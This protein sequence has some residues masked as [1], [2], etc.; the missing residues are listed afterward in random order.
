M[1]RAQ[2]KIVTIEED[3]HLGFKFG[4]QAMVELRQSIGKTKSSPL[5]NMIVSKINGI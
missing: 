1:Q 3:I 4:F 2:F 5:N